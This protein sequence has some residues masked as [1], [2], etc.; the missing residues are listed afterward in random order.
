[1]S[2]AEE[3]GG[4]GSDSDVSEYLSVHGSDG[5]ADE[6]DNAVVVNGTGR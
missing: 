3:N 2:E 5:E 6:E 1:M 4:D